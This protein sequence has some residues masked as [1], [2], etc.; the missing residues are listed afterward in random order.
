MV[1]PP[2]IDSHRT[3]VYSGGQSQY[4]VFPITRHVPPDK[5]YPVG[6][7][8]TTL[9]FHFRITY[10]TSFQ[11]TYRAYWHHNTCPSIHWH[12]YIQPVDLLVVLLRY[13]YHTDHMDLDYRYW[14]LERSLSIRSILVIGT[15][16]T[17][18]LPVLHSSG[19]SILENIDTS[20][21]LHW[22]YTFHHSNRQ[23][24]D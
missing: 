12:N 5:Q 10:S 21:Q 2:I 6:Q 11:Q 20:S 24:S 18:H 19:Q 15:D 8:V 17:A 16:L 1:K 23:H 13:M 9:K 3:P 22:Q 14:S 7:S 4:G